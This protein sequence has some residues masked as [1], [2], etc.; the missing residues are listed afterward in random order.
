MENKNRDIIKF[1]LKIV[2]LIMIILY[3]MYYYFSRGVIANLKDFLMNGDEIL[4]TIS[5][6]NFS[7]ISGGFSVAYSLMQ[8]LGGYLLDKFGIKIIYPL[9]LILASITNFFFISAS[10]VGMMTFYRFL[11]GGFFCI[12][13]TGSMKYISMVW[14][15]H[16]TFV[17]SLSKFLMCFASA[18]AASTTVKIYMNTY[19]WRQILKIYSFIGILFAIILYISLYLVFNKKYNEEIEAP[20]EQEAKNSPPVKLLDGLKYLIK[21]DGF[22]WMSLF[23]LG[24][25]S[26]AYVLMDGWGNSLLHLKYPTVSMLEIVSPATMN[27]Y[28]NGI[29]HLYNIFAK[30]LSLRL[31]M[32]IY[33]ALGLISLLSI[34]YIQNLP[35]NGFLICCFFL[36]FTCSSQ[37]LGFRWVQENVSN[38]YLGLG[39]SILN[40]MCMFFGCAVIQKLTGSLLDMIKNRNLLSGMAY[41]EGYTYLDLLTMFKFLII[42]ALL[43]IL[44]IFFIKDKKN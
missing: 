32:I 16:F 5:A 44:S 6:T 10:T 8:P 23:S 42:P 24:S 19:G 12:A 13:S 9:L 21:K 41:Y 14:K 33:G 30:K 18:I 3:T 26:V 27:M 15:K 40:F 39:F 1:V 4:G 7:Q 20:E 29:G 11:I 25:S 37:N 2:S 38:K 28:G 35:L 22:L 31:Q 43:C 17:F 34:I 36:G